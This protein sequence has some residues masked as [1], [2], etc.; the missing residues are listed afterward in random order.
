MKIS[1]ASFDPPSTARLKSWELARVAQRL[2]DE[3]R[4]RTTGQFSPVNPC[5]D[6]A[7]ITALRKALEILYAYT[8][9]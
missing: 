3:I 2:E 4:D 8:K 1:E 6:P 9:R 5:G 7:D